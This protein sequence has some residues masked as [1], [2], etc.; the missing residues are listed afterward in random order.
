VDGSAALTG[1]CCKSPDYV[2]Y[3]LPEILDL[4]LVQS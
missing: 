4:S 2:R 3:L 1:L